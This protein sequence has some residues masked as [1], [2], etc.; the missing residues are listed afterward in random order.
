MRDPYQR[1][2]RTVLA[3]TPTFKQDTIIWGTPD[4]VDATDSVMGD[5]RNGLFERS[6]S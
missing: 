1:P 5:V 2:N 6:I 4:I 3:P